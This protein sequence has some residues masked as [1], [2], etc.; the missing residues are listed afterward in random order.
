[1]LIVADNNTINKVSANAN[2]DTVNKN[3]SALDVSCTQVFML[4]IT[5]NSFSV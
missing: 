2:T 5:H 3:D 1:M 4:H